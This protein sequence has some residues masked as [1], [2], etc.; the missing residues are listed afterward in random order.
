M[1]CAVAEAFALGLLVVALAGCGSVAQPRS[2]SGRALFG[3]E[4]SSCHSLSGRED[5]RRQGGDLLSFRSSR[6]ALVQLTREMP[7]RRPLSAGGLRA[8]V[9]YVMAVER[10]G[11]E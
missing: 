6:A 5:A 11:H 9:D 7:V 2:P 10:R 1:R 8:V 4:C 3:Q